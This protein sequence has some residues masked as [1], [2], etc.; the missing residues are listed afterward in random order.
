MLANILYYGMSEEITSEGL[1]IGPIKLTIEQ[2]LIGVISNLIT[3]P[4]T[5]IIVQLFR[6]SRARYTRTHR[7]RQVIKETF[8]KN[9]E[10]GSDSEADVNIKFSFLF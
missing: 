10:N 9:H 5:F 1:Q 8:E 2:V 4:P 6:R 7:L 3:F